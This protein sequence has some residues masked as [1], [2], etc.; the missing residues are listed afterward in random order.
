MSLP[1]ETIGDDA[2]PHCD[3][4]GRDAEALRARLG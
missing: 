3:E 2:A 4:C 1:G